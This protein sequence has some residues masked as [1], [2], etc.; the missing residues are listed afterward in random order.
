MGKNQASEELRGSDHQPDDPGFLESVFREAFEKTCKLLDDPKI[1]DLQALTWIIRGRNKVLDETAETY[2]KAAG[3]ECRTG[4]TACCYL[5]LQGTP[6]EVLSIA[7]HLLETRTQGEIEGLKARLQAV[8]EV[9][10]DPALRVKAKIPCALL[11]NG[12]C[13]VYEQRPSLC[14]MTLSQSRAACNSC[15]QQGSGF[16][17]YIEQPSKIAA[18]M[19][20]GIDYALIA[21]R[22]LPTEGAEL[23]R[24]LLVALGDYEGTLTSWLKGK[25][26]FPGTH[27]GVHGAPS[28]TERAI[29]AAK[30][31][32]IA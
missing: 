11:E 24:A 16:I 15:L 7:R 4:C 14:R 23:S 32:G 25:D 13:S 2:A 6:F 28:S 29:A 31:L 12:R 17:P 19:Q 9:P 18:V 10:L 21:R 1:D 20:M 8:S 26:A 3:A 30:R 22:N 5:M 27:V